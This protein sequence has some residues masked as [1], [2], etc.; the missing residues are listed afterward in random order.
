[1]SGLA[2]SRT[3]TR[4]KALLRHRDFRWFAVG[5]GT[6]KLGTAMAPVA[7]AFAVLGTGDATTFGVVLGAR[8]LPIV[9][10]LLFGGVFADRLGGRKVMV[11]SDAVR[12]LAQGLFAVLLLTGRPS[13]G[14]MAALA[15]LN[16]AGEGIF[17]PSLQALVPRIAGVEQLKDANAFLSLTTS[18]AGITGP[19]L[20]GLLAAVAGPASVLG[21]DALT[22]C[23][24]IGVLIALSN[25]PQPVRERSSLLKDLGS[26]WAEFRSR[27][28]LWTTTLQFCLFNALV[29]AP[30]LVLGPVVA[31]DRLGGA[32]AWGLVTAAQ[33][34]GSV[35]AS[36]VVLRRPE[37][38]RPLV[39][40]TIGTLGYAAP[41]AFLAA[42][43]SLSWVC[44]A[45]LI[46][47]AASGYGSL[48]TAVIQREV[49][50]E[51]QGR[52][53]SYQYLGAFALGPL[54]LVA[55]GPLSGVFGVG[56]VLGFAA[57]WQVATVMLTLAVP[58]VRGVRAPDRHMVTMSGLQPQD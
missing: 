52:I 24:S 27:A 19:A 47:G 8:I 2:K 42:G 39:A 57:V 58:S 46:A 9:F 53:A 38:R 56:H 41:P 33:C 54:G 13:V 11:A 25:V 36:V 32:W 26:G 12:A 43:S 55:A 4:V 49:P 21:F 45:A 29:W 17:T 7:L 48:E 5:Y 35:V 23:V 37:P 31:R 30:F 40:V 10:L 1:L 18:A 16:G 20:G 15:V 14:V 6:S 28:W 22:Y 50:L 44:V 51:A 34:V 3:L